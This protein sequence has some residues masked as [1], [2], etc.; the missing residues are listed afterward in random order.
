M[1]NIK[2]KLKGACKLVAGVV[3][4]AAMLVANAIIAVLPIACTVAVVV[5]TLKF[6]GVL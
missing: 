4:V 2:R 3:A 1:K 6:M 5:Y